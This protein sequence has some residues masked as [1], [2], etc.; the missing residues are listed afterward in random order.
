MKHHRNWSRF[1]ADGSYWMYLVH[2]PLVTLMT[3]MMFNWSVSPIY[4][5]ATASIVTLI[6]CL[7]TYKYFVRKSFIGILLN[8]RRAK[9]T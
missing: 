2:L 6:I 5:F 9:K 1:I 8:G 4:K 7:V 3:F